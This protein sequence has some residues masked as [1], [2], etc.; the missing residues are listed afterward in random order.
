MFEAE[1]ERIIVIVENTTAIDLKGTLLADVL[2]VMKILHASKRG[3]SAQILAL[4][5][6]G[7]VAIDE[8][9]S[10]RRFEP[11][12]VIS[13]GFLRFFFRFRLIGISRLRGFLGGETD[14]EAEH[15]SG[16]THCAES[17]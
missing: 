4:L 7:F 8:R 1:L 3:A 14:R 9:S 10:D 6:T 15:P 17:E 13:F 2:L 16:H 5:E 12:P 11:A